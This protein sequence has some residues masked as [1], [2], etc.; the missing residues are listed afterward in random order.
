MGKHIT[1]VE[2]QGICSQTDAMA[3]LTW[4]EAYRNKM[5]TEVGD[6]S[7]N[8]RSCKRIYLA[9]HK[10][11]KKGEPVMNELFKSPT[12]STMATAAASLVAGD[13]SMP[14]SAQAEK[15][16]EAGQKDAIFCK[17]E[18]AGEEASQD[19]VSSKR[20]V[21]NVSFDEV[22]VG[23]KVTI[24]LPGLRGNR[25][26]TVIQAYNPEKPVQLARLHGLNSPTPSP[27]VS[28]KNFS[29]DQDAEMRELFPDLDKIE[30]MAK[31][32]SKESTA[33]SEVASIAEPV[34]VVEHFNGETGVKTTFKLDQKYWTTKGAPRKWIGRGTKHELVKPEVLEKRANTMVKLKMTFRTSI[35]FFNNFKTETIQ[36]RLCS[37]KFGFHIEV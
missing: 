26:A 30:E 34:H 27:E 25:Q 20:N 13:A 9:G 24:R 3:G 8:I 29:A 19:S 22:T 18:K 23:M 5:G 10:N 17:A 16:D 32:Q 21:A 2:K 36:I 28:T 6:R 33:R 31:E 12:D 1:D 7:K 11:V 14:A 35:T 4:L 15:K 37:S